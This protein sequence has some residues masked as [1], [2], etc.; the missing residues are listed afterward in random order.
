MGS[1]EPLL[2]RSARAAGLF[3]LV[4]VLTGL[5]AMFYLPSRIEFEGDAAIVAQ[6]ILAHE[7][8]F[9]TG[10]LNGIAS[11]AIWVFLVLALDR[12]FRSV[13]PGQ[14]NLLVALVL[15][16]IPVMLTIEVVSLAALAILQ[17]GLLGSLPLIQRQE[18][19][20]VFLRV[21]E[22][23]AQT[24]TAFWGLWLLP[25]GILVYRS[26][27]LP[28]AIGVWLYVNGI[29]Y[30]VIGAAGILAPVSKPTIFTFATP[31]LFG[32]IALM[33]WLLV[34]GAKVPAARNEASQ[35]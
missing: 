2:Q 26:R 17:G 11:A 8:L 12:L 19:A 22:A 10:I 33:L 5:F 18:F 6:S 20:F 24:L 3:Y 32:E 21:G 13:D 29:A 1:D 4:W 31:A 9:R 16:Q 14:S 35:C 15:V 30:V 25:L 28:R 27:F 34:R 23:A 7:L